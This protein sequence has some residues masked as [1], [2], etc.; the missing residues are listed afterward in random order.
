MAKSAKARELYDAL[1]ALEGKAKAISRKRGDRYSR[2]AVARAADGRDSS[3]DKRIGEWLHE[4][5]T[6]AKTPDPASSDHLIA[7]IRVWSEWAGEP[8]AESHWRT[9]LDEAQP[10][11]S[12][13]ALAKD[14]SDSHDVP[15]NEAEEPRL[16]P[17]VRKVFRL[18]HSF[19][20]Q[21]APQVYIGIIRDWL[22]EDA[23]LLAQV[24]G[25]LSAR[26]L[27]ARSTKPICLTFVPGVPNFELTEKGRTLGGD[28]L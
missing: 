7:V 10:S 4:D 21:G 22:G 15:P 28:P 16:Q 3:L 25:Y 20:Q 17:A 27:I 5:W 19:T 11:R 24:I 23:D 18:L 8:V 14:Q 9:L 1:R 26:Q 6:T 13:P 2:R 12:R